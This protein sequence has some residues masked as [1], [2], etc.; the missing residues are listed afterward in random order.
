M[1]HCRPVCVVRLVANW[2][3][4]GDKDGQKLRKEPNA[5]MCLGMLVPDLEQH[6]FAPPLVI[7]CG[8]WHENQQL[9]LPEARSWLEND[10]DQVC[11]LSA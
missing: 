1:G 4:T 3:H 5:G 11:L 8:C 2:Q 9:L 6:D 7:E 10:N